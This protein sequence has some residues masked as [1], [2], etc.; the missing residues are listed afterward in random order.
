MHSN[1]RSSSSTGSGDADGFHRQQPPLPSVGERSLLFSSLPHTQ[2]PLSAASAS[3][4][5]IGSQ[6]Q[7]GK[8]LRFFLA[9]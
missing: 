4:Q 2:Q 1:F 6:L 7:G 9:D 3:L 5:K 8:K